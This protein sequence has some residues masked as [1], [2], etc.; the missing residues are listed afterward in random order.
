[1]VYLSKQCPDVLTQMWTE[2]SQKDC[3]N[4]NKAE[5]KLSVHALRGQFTVFVF[6]SLHKFQMVRHFPH[7]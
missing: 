1:M 3:L 4:F 6:R 2:W 5:H 7:L